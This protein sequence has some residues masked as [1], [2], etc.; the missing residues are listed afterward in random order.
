[1]DYRKYGIISGVFFLL[2]ALAH[3]YRVAASL[4]VQV[5]DFM[6]PMWASWVATVVTAVL[7]FWGFRIAR[8]K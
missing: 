8:Q 1:M 7:A 2:I 5:E 6:I 3:L 4:P